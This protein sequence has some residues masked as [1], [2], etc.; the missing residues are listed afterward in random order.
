MDKIKKYSHIV[1]DVLERL[2]TRVPAN[3]PTLRKH[4]VIDEPKNEFILIS[5]GNHKGKYNYT[6]LAH[7]EIKDDKILIHEESV[8]PSIFERLTD[9]GIPEAD[10]LPIYLPDFVTLADDY[11]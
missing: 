4:L 6:V 7:V 3:A 2:S 9:A 11:R 8:D 10:I 1:R 5:L